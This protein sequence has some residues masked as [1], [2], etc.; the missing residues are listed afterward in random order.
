MSHSINC[1]LHNV[2]NTNWTKLNTTDGEFT[3]KR[4]QITNLQVSNICVI[5]SHVADRY[6]DKRVSMY[7]LTL[8]FT[9]IYVLRSVALI[10][11]VLEH[12]NDYAQIH[13]DQLYI[14]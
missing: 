1:H 8:D 2:R 13:L 7:A 10:T 11:R 5:I 3:G 6:S 12:W 9:K 14:N 4:A